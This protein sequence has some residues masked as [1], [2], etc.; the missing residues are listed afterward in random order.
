MED[1]PRVFSTLSTTVADLLATQ[2]ARAT[3]TWAH[4]LSLA[5]SKLRLCS[6]NHRAGYFSNLACDWLSI[7]WA[8]S[9]QETENGPRL[10]HPKGSRTFP[11]KLHERHDSENFCP[12]VRRLLRPMVH[13]PDKKATIDVS[14]L[15]EQPQWYS[16]PPIG[17]CLSWEVLFSILYKYCVSTVAHVASKLYCWVNSSETC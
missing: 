3:T 4:F 1:Q 16:L 6:A 14:L 13:S 11:I 5:W 8:Y 10:H 15:S 9:E 17:N 7:V 12:F 2:G